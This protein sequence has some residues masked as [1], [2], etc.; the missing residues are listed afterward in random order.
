MSK[1]CEYEHEIG[2]AGEDGL[3]G[4]DGHSE[5]CGEPAVGIVTESYYDESYDTPLCA[6]HLPVY[7]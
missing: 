4:D 6:E 3:I 7:K 2:I 5:Q 1:V